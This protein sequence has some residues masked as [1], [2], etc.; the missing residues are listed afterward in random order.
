M[1]VEKTDVVV[2]EDSEFEDADVTDTAHTNK[3][4]DENVWEKL[5]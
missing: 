1:D 3:T 4:S 2:N 5:R